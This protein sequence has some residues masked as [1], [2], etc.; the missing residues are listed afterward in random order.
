LY[1]AILTIVNHRISNLRTV[2][3]LLT[4]LQLD[5]ICGSKD[6]ILRD[7]DVEMIFKIQNTKMYISLKWTD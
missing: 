4:A 6:A 5:T 3:L 2:T 7:M 1:I